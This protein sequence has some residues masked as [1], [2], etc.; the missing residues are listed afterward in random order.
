MLSN[1]AIYIHS[2]LEGWDG[3][4]YTPETKRTFYKFPQRIIF[5]RLI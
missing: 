2:L 3:K 5:K 1:K 4:V